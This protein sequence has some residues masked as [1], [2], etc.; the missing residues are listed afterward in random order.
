MQ[1]ICSNSYLITLIISEAKNKALKNVDSVF[2]ARCWLSAGCW[3]SA[4]GAG[5]L[6]WVLAFCAVCW[7]SALGAGFLLWVLVCHTIEKKT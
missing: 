6:Q 5:F 7:L 2:Y 4:N 3:L 1:Y